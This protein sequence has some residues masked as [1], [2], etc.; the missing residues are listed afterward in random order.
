MIRVTIMWMILIF[1]YS[2]SALEEGDWIIRI[3]GAKINVMASSDELITEGAGVLEG[4]E[5]DVGDKSGFAGSLGYMLTEN[6]GIE[7]LFG[8]PFSH[9]VMPNAELAGLIGPANIVSFKHIPPV[10]SLNYHFNVNGGNIRPYIGGGINYVHFFD[11]ETTGG[12]KNLGY[13][14]VAIEDS[15]GLALQAGI[16]YDLSKNIFVNFN[17]RW[18]D[19]NTEA[20]IGRA[21]V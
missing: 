15:W 5:I 13:T 16:D 8:Q 1:P 6:W 18:V 7:V 9:D 11:E 21:H 10:L 19:V 3:G 12:L 2:A 17:V 4:T 20:K 14:E